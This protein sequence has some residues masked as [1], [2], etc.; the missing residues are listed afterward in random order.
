M[1]I[2]NKYNIGDSVWIMFN[3]SPLEVKIRGIYYGNRFKDNIDDPAL[4]YTITRFSFDYLCLEQWLFPTK[5][6]L[7]TSL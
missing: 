4:F 1:N 2:E 7:I 3:N 6:E 5:E